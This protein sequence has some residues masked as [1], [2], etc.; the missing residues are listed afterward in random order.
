MIAEIYEKLSDEVKQEFQVD[1]SQAPE[2][3]KWWAFDGM[4]RWYGKG[5]V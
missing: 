4:E 3:S 2:W 1:W 5:E